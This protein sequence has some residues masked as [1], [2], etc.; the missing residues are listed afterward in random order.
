MSYKPQAAG[1]NTRL[2]PRAMHA[3]GLAFSTP[4]GR[5]L[6]AHPLRN[7]GPRGEGP[8]AGLPTRNR[9][10]RPS[11]TVAPALP[12]AFLGRRICH[13][14]QT[15]SVGWTSPPV[16]F[17]E[18]NQGISHEE[19]NFCEIHCRRARRPSQ[20]PYVSAGGTT[21]RGLRQTSNDNRGPSP[22]FAAVCRTYFCL[23]LNTRY[24]WFNRRSKCNLP[25]VMPPCSSF[26]W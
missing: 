17:F 10:T 19:V 20:P 16:S 7:G 9:G 13:T 22:V 12:P 15:S 8:A 1:D 25:F 26:L 5:G 21:M 4:Q 3:P 6:V 18:K 2:V 14:A 24:P 23:T 11:G